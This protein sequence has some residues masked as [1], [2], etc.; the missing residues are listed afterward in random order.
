MV[1]IRDGRE[2]VLLSA[3]T[4]SID[5]REINSVHFSNHSLIEE[6]VNASLELTGDF[7]SN[8]VPKS[9]MVDGDPKKSSAWWFR[10]TN[11]EESC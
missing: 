10:M 2:A 4:I 8:V 7:I 11:V 3:S 1:R 6:V 9:Q 5:R